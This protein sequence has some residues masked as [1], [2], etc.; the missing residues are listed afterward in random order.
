MQS[1]AM[2]YLRVGFHCDPGA[3]L[4]VSTDRD[5]RFLLDHRSSHGLWHDYL[6]MRDEVWELAGDSHCVAVRLMKRYA[7]RNLLRHVVRR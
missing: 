5:V 3:D 1:T 7:K 4:T 6:H 2:N